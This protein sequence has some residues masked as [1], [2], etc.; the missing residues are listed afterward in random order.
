MNPNLPLLMELTVTLPPKRLGETK[1]DRLC[2]RYILLVCCALES[3][4]MEG[5]IPNISISLPYWLGFSLA[6]NDAKL[7]CKCWEYI[8]MRNKSNKINFQITTGKYSKMYQLETSVGS[9]Y[10]HYTVHIHWPIKFWV[11]N[12]WIHK[13]VYIN[14]SI[15]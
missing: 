15:S 7:I 11:L 9:S 4:L 1:D 8:C 14:H 5:T 2:L 12:V 10:F 13:T 6:G 3:F